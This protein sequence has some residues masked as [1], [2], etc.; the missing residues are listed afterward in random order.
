MFI[1]NGIAVI[2]LHFFSFAVQAQ[3]SVTLNV[4]LYPIQTLVVNAEQKSVDLSYNTREDYKNGVVSEQKDHLTIY[5]TGGFQVKVNAIAASATDKTFENIAVLPTSGSQ[6]LSSSHVVYTQKNISETAQP[7]ISATKGAFNKNVN[8]SYKGAAND[9]FAD[10]ANNNS[11]T[12]KSYTIVYTI[13][14][15]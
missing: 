14:S 12:N 2:A 8:I 5:S 15:Q 4:N 10:F 9:T 1:K 11:I 6:P 7:I 13:I 3:S